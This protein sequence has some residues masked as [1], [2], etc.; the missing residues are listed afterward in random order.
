[1]VM[2]YNQCM[3][4]I[5][6]LFLINS[7][8][9]FALLFTVALWKCEPFLLRRV[10]LASFAGGIWACF[11]ALAR[12]QD[13]R[14]VELLTMYPA[15]Y[16]MTGIAFPNKNK[17]KKKSI[18]NYFFMIACIGG[19]ILNFLYYELWN[20]EETKG[21]FGRIVITLFVWI[22]ALV[23]I[24]RYR[25]MELQ[26]Q[27]TS[28]IYPVELTVCGNKIKIQAL[29]DS[30]NR[31]QNTSGEPVCIVEQK[32][33]ERLVKEQWESLNNWTMAEGT[34]L[35][36]KGFQL[37]SYHCIGREE[38]VFP[39]IRGDL[40]VIQTENG[41][42]TIKRPVIGY[43]ESTFSIENSMGNTYEM[44]LPSAYGVQLRK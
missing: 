10:L 33:M 35:F 2:C 6:I 38:G 5:D 32:V 30:G 40:I 39:A 24:L 1:M 8:L 13:A 19:G 36:E 42:I 27:E 14:F 9:D 31:L 17:K 29:W 20:L 16:I 4:Y 11:V 22:I 25:Q 3:L 18:V 21:I 44:L 28:V 26:K 34:F 23:A 43:C 15:A 12:I 41:E 37:I 7:L